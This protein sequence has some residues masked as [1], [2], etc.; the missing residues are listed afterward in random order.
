MPPNAMRRTGMLWLTCP[1]AAG[2]KAAAVAF[3]RNVLRF[4][5]GA[6]ELGLRRTVYNARSYARDWGRAQLATSSWADQRVPARLSVPI[7]AYFRERHIW[8][9][10]L[11]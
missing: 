4:K 11:V 6:P 8:S 5:A 7:R 1:A 2:V 3:F 10:S 9:A